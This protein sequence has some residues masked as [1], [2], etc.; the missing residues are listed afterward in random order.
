MKR[1]FSFLPVL[2]LFVLPFVT[3]Q[4]C[5]PDFYPDV[6]VH[7][8]HPDKPADY[9]AG[10]LGV[11]LPTYPRLDLAVAY[12]YLNGGTLSA[13]EQ[14][15]Y[16]PTLSYGEDSKEINAEFDKEIAQ[17][18][19]PGPAD[20]WLKARS[21]YAPAQPE[22]HEVQQ[23]GT[24]YRA[25]FVLAGEYENC[26]A[27]A[28]R[29][30]VATLESRAKTWGTHSP[31]LADWIKGQDAV[32][33][34][35]GS[36][37][38]FSY[39]PS[40]RP[41]IQPSSP[42]AAAPTA[43]LLLRQD[44]AY[45]AA[46]AQFYA[47]QFAPARASFQAIAED[48]A[49]PWRGIA[50]YLVA[51]TLIRDA[52]LNAKR[53]AN[54]TRADFNPDLMKQAEQ[55]L[56]SLRKQN[57]PGISAH[58]VQGMLNLVHLRTQPDVRLREM[59]DAL[60]GPKPDP[61]YKQDLDD[62]I[63]YLN[64]EL[65]NLAIRESAEGPIDF[66]GDSTQHDER[67]RQADEM[68][69]DYEK[70]YADVAHLRSIAPLI[71]WLVTFQSPSAAARKHAVA[72]WKR[73]GETPWLAAAIM[74]TPAA[75][76]ATPALMDAASHVAPSSPAWTTVTY[77]RLR[78]LIGSGRAAEARAELDRALP[79]LKTAGSD[80]ALNLFTGLR[81]RTGPTLDSALADAPRKI[82][83]RTS[84]EQSSLDD[85]LAVMK[86][87]KRKYDCKPA[88]SPVEFSPDAAGVFNN[89]MP[90][91]ALAEAAQ[92][93][94][95]PGQ[96]RSSVAMVTWVRA[97]LLKNEAVAAQLLPLL[98]PK[99]QQQAGSGVGLHPVMAIL[100]NPGLRPYLD[101]GVQRSA[102][103]D[104]VESYADNWWCS[105]WTNSAFSEN[106]APVRAQSVAFLSPEER[107][108]GEAETSA[109]LRLGSAEA[110]L[111]TQIVEYARAHPTGPDVPEALYL[112]LR[113]IRYGCY[114]ANSE[115]PDSKDNRVASIALEIGAMMRH[116]YSSDPWTKKAAPYVWPVKKP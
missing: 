103:Y 22:I 112:T 4:A 29:T 33:S 28:S 10:K 50:G 97:V 23:Y 66:E 96:L 31:E 15:V 24:T 110:H 36:S 5:G 46:A 12:R 8:I 94:T 52:F 76:E 54:D 70:A 113:T 56:E 17:P 59:S 101:G 57:P 16:K 1:L 102:S 84:E 58:A 40:N 116:R 13:E 64:G 18:E 67:R 55:Q 91:A 62:L 75:D 81:M 68:T 41:K 6:F 88:S 63:W 92:S 3:V 114:H 87:P 49:S 83:E 14:T 98:P 2:I 100:R 35:C 99:L 11:L 95:L 90:L 44:R 25:G 72:E 85:C 9:A 60:A 38:S 47:A 78:L 79:N 105:N 69:P 107:K 111:G 45:Q 93:G 37:G 71:D 106:G 61:Y 74:K 26:Q 82:L 89:E 20:L 27:D 51:R 48:Q 65:D 109:L 53:D 7:Q 34:N 43:P 86:N 108:A 80:S 73:T 19:P 39:F 32:F 115:E 77:H 104:F 30:A 21:R 42:S